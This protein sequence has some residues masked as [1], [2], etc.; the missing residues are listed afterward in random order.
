[1]RCETRFETEESLQEVMRHIWTRLGNLMTTSRVCRPSVCLLFNTRSFSVSR[2][3]WSIGR[4]AIT[5]GNW[6]VSKLIFM[7][8]AT[9]LV[10]SSCVQLKRDS[11]LHLLVW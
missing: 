1:M 10:C 11:G 6:R 4:G 5:P 9:C 2:V 8:L 3:R 7:F